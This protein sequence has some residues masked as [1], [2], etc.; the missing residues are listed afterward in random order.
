MISKHKYTFFSLIFAVL[1]IFG[2]MIAMNYIL[3]LRETQLLT[4]RGRAEVESPVREWLEWGTS[5]EFA[6]DD[7]HQERYELTF[8]Q[9]EEAVSHWNSREGDIIH[10]PVAGQISMGEAIEGGKEWLVAMGFTAGSDEVPAYS[11]SATL[12]VGTKRETLNTKLEPYYSFWTIQYS[13]RILEA[14]VL[15]NAVTGKVWGAKVTIYEDVPEKLN[16]GDAKTFWEMAGLQVS[17]TDFLEINDE[18]TREI[19]GAEGTALYVRTGYSHFNVNEDSIVDYNN[20][21]IFHKEYAVITYE[22]VVG[23]G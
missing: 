9:M 2:S 11:V 15:V 19:Y 1:F 5:G 17:E 22:F 14:E 23:E 6:S 16:E 4:E 12:S 3:K 8:R 21:G 10:E 18:Q 20:L 7:M 13:N